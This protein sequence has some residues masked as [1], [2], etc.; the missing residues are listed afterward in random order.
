VLELAS[1]N[2]RKGERPFAAILVD[3]NNNV[4]ARCGNSMISTGNPL[5]H[6]ELLVI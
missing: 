2:V 5:A 3:S 1:E 6:A 4:I